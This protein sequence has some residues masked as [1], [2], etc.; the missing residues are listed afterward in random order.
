MVFQLDGC[1]RC[2]FHVR[3]RPIRS[4]TPFDR[5]ELDPL[6]AVHVLTVTLEI[7]YRVERKRAARI[8]T[9]E[10]LALA[11]FRGSIARAFQLPQMFLQVLFPT[12]LK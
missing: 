1:V 12:L 2:S 4:A 8:R 6:D 9:R 3:R 10:R 11:R 7:L 5:I